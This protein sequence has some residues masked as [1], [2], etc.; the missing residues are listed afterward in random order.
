[1]RYATRNYIYFLLRR[2]GIWRGLPL[3]IANQACFLA[4]LLPRFD[5]RAVYQL[6]QASFR[7]AIQMYRGS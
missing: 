6:K 5:N 1:M 2:F 4:R 3:L 7:E